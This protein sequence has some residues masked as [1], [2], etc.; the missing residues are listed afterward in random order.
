MFSIPPAAATVVRCVSV[1][2]RVGHGHGGQT[3]HMHNAM[4]T[5]RHALNELRIRPNYLWRRM[6]DGRK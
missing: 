6:M 2:S 5:L 3:R 4:A 1:R